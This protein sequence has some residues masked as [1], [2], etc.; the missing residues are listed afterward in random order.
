MILCLKGKQRSWSPKVRIAIRFIYPSLPRSLSWSKNHNS[1]HIHHCHDHGH[2]VPIMIRFVIHHCHI[3]DSWVFM[4]IHFTKT[5]GHRQTLFQF[6]S[7]AFSRFKAGEK[8]EKKVDFDN[9]L[10]R[11]GLNWDVM[12]TV[13]RDSTR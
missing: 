12:W 13:Q 4:H 8:G 11:K 5:I 1:F 10:S 6:R 9:W 2:D 3:H 7:W